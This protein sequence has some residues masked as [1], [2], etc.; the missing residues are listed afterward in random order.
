M[1]LCNIEI[2]LVFVQDYFYLHLL[3]FSDFTFP[4]LNNTSPNA[5]IVSYNL[6][7]SYVYIFYNLLSIFFSIKFCTYLIY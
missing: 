2:S 7:Y 4:V 6:V 5:N 3:K 1:T